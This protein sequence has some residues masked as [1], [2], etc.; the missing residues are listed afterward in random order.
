MTGVKLDSRDYEDESSFEEDL[1]VLVSNL[2]GYDFS[3]DLATT[4]AIV[5]PSSPTAFDSNM[6]PLL[7]TG[8]SAQSVMMMANDED[9]SASSMDEQEDKRRIN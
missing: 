3:N 1:S 4:T 2:I 5:A 9:D 6:A 8:K 7:M